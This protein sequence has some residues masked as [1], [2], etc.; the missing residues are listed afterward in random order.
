[1]YKSEIRDSVFNQLLEKVERQ[2]YGKYLRKIKLKR[3]RGFKEQVICLDFP[4]TAL[5]GPNG[6]GK[7]TILGAAACAYKMI[8]PR[9]FFAKVGK[10]DDSMQNWKIEY[11][12]IDR[13]INKNSVIQR[14]AT[15]RNYKWYREGLERTVSIFGVS[16]TIPPSEWAGLSRWATSSLEIPDDHVKT[17]SPIVT[18]AVGKILGKD[19]SNFNEAT[20]DSAGKVTLLTGMTQN[21]E[22]YSEFHFGAGESSVIRMVMAIENIPEQSLILIEEIENGLHPVA[23]IRMVEYLIEMCHRK[24]SQVIFTTHSDDALTPLPNK[25]IWAAMSNTAFQG[26]LDIDSLRIITGQIESQLAIFVEDKFAKTWLE[27][28]I[29]HAQGISR[30]QIEV[31]A[32]E[33]DSVAANMNKFHN[34][35]P[36]APYRSICFIDGDSNVDDSDEDKVYRLH[37]G[38]PESYVYNRVLDNFDEIGGQLCISLLQPFEKTDS[39]KEILLDVKLT[40]QDP[41]L[42]FSK[43]GRKLG[44]LPQSTIEAAFASLWAQIYSEEA[45]EITDLIRKNLPNR[46]TT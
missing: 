32:M 34:A 41:H 17:L 6:G 18:N 39:V 14:T 10:F 20:I 13:D 35:D 11:E 15:F 2:S 42:L 7:T 28:I 30:D 12:I 22:T 44:F 27:A 25:A 3:I 8:R 23:T 21:G 1:M 4:V 29:R 38:V 9:Q 5:I 43:V 19:V 26:K 24:K 16:R 36:S 45:S 46:Q 40:T 37:G 33:G 31:Y